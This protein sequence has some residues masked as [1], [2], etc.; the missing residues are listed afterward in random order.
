MS[1][2]LILDGNQRSALAATRSLG[3]K[4]HKVYVVDSTP[5]S[6]AGSSR[7]CAGYIQLVDI[8]IHHERFIEELQ[9]LISKYNIE[10]L[11]PMTDVSTATI[12][13][14][15]DQFQHVNIPAPPLESYNLASDKN[16]LFKLALQLNVPIPKTHFISSITQIETAIEDVTYPAVIKPSCSRILINGQWV[17][18]HVSFTN[19]KDDLLDQIKN[20]NWLNSHPFMI[21]EHIK[22]Q[23]QGVFAFYNKGKPVTFFAHKRL[24]EKPPSGGV[25]VLRESIPI[26]IAMR[27][28]SEKLL[29][30][31]GW[32]GAAMIEFIVS[33]DG[34]PYLIE[35]NGRFWGSLQL[36]ID[37]RKQTTTH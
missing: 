24:R 14:R 1:N 16:S 35:I 31:I 21:Q 6:L 25:S 26:D 36:S 12:L 37:A 27:E 7:H 5:Q 33:S 20:T 19:S 3:I 13:S 28:I 34:T 23:G 22:G 4:G 30:K 10:V 8:D 18:T 32:H 9:A 2:I 29:E 15:P 17:S 11:M